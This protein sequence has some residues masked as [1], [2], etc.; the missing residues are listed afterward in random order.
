MYNGFNMDYSNLTPAQISNELPNWLAKFDASIAY[1]ALEP[2]MALRIQ[3][4]GWGEWFL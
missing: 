3:L 2:A 1:L 4:V